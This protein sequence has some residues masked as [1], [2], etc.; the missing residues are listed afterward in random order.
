MQPVS[1]SI[2]YDV[3]VTSQLNVSALWSDYSH[4]SVTGHGFHFLVHGLQL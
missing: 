1:V 4:L 3:L 2:L